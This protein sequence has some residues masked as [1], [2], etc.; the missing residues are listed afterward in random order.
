MTQKTIFEIHRELCVLTDLLMT[1]IYKYQRL[2]LVVTQLKFHSMNALLDEFITNQAMSR[3]DVRSLK[4]MIVFLKSYCQEM[5]SEM[6]EGDRITIEGLINSIDNQM[7]TLKTINK[8]KKRL[9]YE[10]F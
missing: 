6:F 10:C 7:A 1:E 9:G 2:F 5:K 4:K 3:Y 8:E